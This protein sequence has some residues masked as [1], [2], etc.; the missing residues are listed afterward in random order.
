MIKVLDK[1]RRCKHAITLLALACATTYILLE[2]VKVEA[3]VVWS[4]N[5]VVAIIVV[6]YTITSL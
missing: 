6:L 1:I 5:T 3:W 2:L 4:I